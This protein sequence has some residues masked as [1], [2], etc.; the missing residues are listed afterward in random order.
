MVPRGA[1]PGVPVRAGSCGKR[2]C[3]APSRLRGL[4]RARS[5]DY[6]SCVRLRLC[7]RPSGWRV[8][9]LRLAH[10]RLISTPVAK[11]EPAQ[12]TYQYSIS[13]SIFATFFGCSIVTA[14]T[15]LR[16]FIRLYSAVMPGYS[17]SFKNTVE[18]CSPYLTEATRPASPTESCIILFPPHH[19]ADRRNGT[20]TVT[21]QPYGPCK[22]LSGRQNARK[23][24]PPRQ[25]RF[26]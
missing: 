6:L 8:W 10:P 14:F 18:V 7:Q 1:G 4:V 15:S 17:C 21:Q 25:T 5:L 20:K 3:G 12:S 9:L 19:L 22:D 24:Y 26:Y 23:V 13:T 16:L 11:S 2:G